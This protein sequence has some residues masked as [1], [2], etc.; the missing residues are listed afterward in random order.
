V[1]KSEEHSVTYPEQNKNFQNAY[2]WGLLRGLEYGKKLTKHE[3]RLLF[4]QMD[5]EPQALSNPGGFYAD[6]ANK[7][8]SERVDY[9]IVVAAKLKRKSGG[10]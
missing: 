5:S 8:D 7:S 10:D 4:K 2:L 1:F 9:Y 3:R 6:R